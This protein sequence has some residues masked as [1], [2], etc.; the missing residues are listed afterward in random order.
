MYR[1]KQGVDL[2]G[3]R[4]EMILSWPIMATV[5]AKYGYETVIT[6]VC[7]GEHKSLVHPVG[8]GTDYRTWDIPR[9]EQEKIVEDAQK[10]L[11]E[12]YDVVLEKDHIH[13]E[14]DPRG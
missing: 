1:F 4:P 6:S 9:E 14:F 3:V 13:T 10:A 7:D 5:F 2:R 11:G 8:L 12:S